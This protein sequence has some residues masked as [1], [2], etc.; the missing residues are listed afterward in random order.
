VSS[1]N[2]AAY[3]Q[4]VTFTATVTTQD[5]GTPSGTVTF[6]DGTAN[7]GTASLSNGS[8]S[9]S[10]SALGVGLHSITA[11]YSGDSN[12]LPTVSAV[13][14]QSVS[15]AT[16][17]T[18]LAS[19]ANPS[20]LNQSVTFTATVKSQYAAA[21]TG[22]VTFKQ[23]STA[24]GT[25]ALEN[26]QAASS[27]TYTTTGT[28]DITTVYAGDSNNRGSTSAV[29]SQVVSTLPAATT[30][31]VSTSGSPTFINQPVMFTAKITSTYGPI[32]DGNTVTFYDGTTVM[33]IGITSNGVT[34]FSTSTLAARTHT[35]K[36]T[37]VGDATFKSSSGTVTQVVN[38]YP[39]SIT[40]PASSRNPSIYGQS[41]TLSATVTSTAPS[42][43]TGTV[44]FEN[45]TTSI[46]SA[47][48]STSGVATLTKNS[49]AAGTLSITAT[50]NGDSETAKS[51]SAG[52][53]Q[54][55]SAATSAT[56]VKSSLNPSLSGQ[57]LT[58]TATVTS[59]QTTP[60]GTVTFSD[61]SNTLGTET[62]SGG[63]ARYSTTTLGTGSHSISVIYNGTANINGSTSA[64]LVQNV[65]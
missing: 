14:G 60:T 22:N 61:G 11:S 30:N 41:V 34:T 47:T 59:P 36:A 16:T 40:V 48:I 17:T 62:V 4:Q 2:P 39:S 63:R 53:L 46:G 56:T 37:Y 27:T 43:P 19:S 54:T 13:L 7:L 32:P 55:V 49:L 52:L 64:T 12:F 25:V 35:I 15:Q 10:T 24:V 44:V 51:T 42:S 26:G 28:R 1:L 20:Y 38:P 31:K 8:A 50:Y 57:T 9:L 5:S 21:V 33:G 6:K 23:G 58:F 3:E 29:L 18:A 65:N 45:G